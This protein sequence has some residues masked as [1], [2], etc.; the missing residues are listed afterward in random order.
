[1]R[2]GKRTSGKRLKTQVSGQ[3]FAKRALARPAHAHRVRAK[4]K[5]KEI[6]SRPRSNPTVYRESTE[7]AVTCS[8]SED[9]AQDNL[10]CRSALAHCSYR[11]LTDTSLTNRVHRTRR[12]QGWDARTKADALSLLH[13]NWAGPGPWKTWEGGSKMKQ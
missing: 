11:Y 3:C 6:L 10:S 2:G 4:E 1:M 8:C 12:A 7:P 5:E 13:N 9:K